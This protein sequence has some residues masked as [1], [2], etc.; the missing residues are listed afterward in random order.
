[1]LHRELRSSDLR[2]VHDGRGLLSCTSCIFEVLL[3]RKV[4]AKYALGSCNWYFSLIIMP[5]DI[6][7]DRSGQKLR[8]RASTLAIIRS[9]M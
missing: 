1:M 3:E 5:I 6:F 8:V 2:G 4:A 9:G 7:L